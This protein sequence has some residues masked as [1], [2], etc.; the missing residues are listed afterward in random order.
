MLLVE[1]ILVMA[2]IGIHI[3]RINEMERFGGIVAGYHI[4]CSAILYGHVIQPSYPNVPYIIEANEILQRTH[5][6]HARS[7]EV[8]N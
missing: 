3:G 6:A 1:R 5:T 4:E 2:A 7:M 8:K